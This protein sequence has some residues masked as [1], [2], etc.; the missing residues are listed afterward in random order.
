MQGKLFETF[1]GLFSMKFKQYIS[2]DVKKWNGKHLLLIP[3]FRF[4][5]LKRKC[6]YWHE[7]TIYYQSLIDLFT[8]DTK[9]SI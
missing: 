6:E 4:V 3:Q 7:K 1:I 9:L 2:D 5:F 8:E